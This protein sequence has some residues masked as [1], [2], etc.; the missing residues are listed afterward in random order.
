MYKYPRMCERL[1]V[2]SII[3]IL[4]H[5]Y[6]LYQAHNNVFDRDLHHGVCQDL[7]PSGTTPHLGWQLVPTWSTPRY[8]RVATRASRALSRPFVYEDGM[9][10]LAA[11]NRYRP[12]SIAALMPRPS[13]TGSIGTTVR[14]SP[15]WSLPSTTP[16]PSG[17]LI[18]NPCH[19]SSMLVR[20]RNASSIISMHALL[21]GTMVYFRT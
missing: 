1:Y 7:F 6:I 12:I 11:M 5:F 19:L 14:T 13:L 4:K 2:V 18:Q 10:H 20:D 8:A 16:A 15:R 17:T 21:D 9:V 3:S